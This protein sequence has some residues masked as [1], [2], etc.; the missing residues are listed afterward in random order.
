MGLILAFGLTLAVGRYQDR[1]ADVV[2]DANTIGTAYLRA[3]TIAEPQ[4]E[5]SLALLRRY[6]D[7]AIQVTLEIPG[8]PA[9]RAT[10][11]QEGQL[12]QR[13]W[14]LAGEA[15]NA[16]PRDSAPRLY[17]E[18]LNAMIDQ[19]GV[20]L[21]GLNN[22]VPNAVLWLELVGAAVATALLALHLSV[23]GRGLVPVVT[24]AILVSF[25]VLVTFDLDRPTRGLITIPA[26]PLLAVK[27]TM[28]LPPAA[29]AP[30]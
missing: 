9:L 11:A 29:P 5:A 22:R 19:Q 14:R 3:Q 15:M 2:N 1:R 4:R 16:R 13:L 20:R 12:Q 26:T 25:L 7:L 8:S 10:T 6:N 27:A 23:I 24:A 21:A 17:V 18:S 30:R 28:S